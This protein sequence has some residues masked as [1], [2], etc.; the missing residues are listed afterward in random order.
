MKINPIDARLQTPQDNPLLT[1]TA[2]TDFYRTFRDVSQKSDLRD[3]SKTAPQGRTNEAE[4]SSRKSVDQAPNKTERNDSDTEHDSEQ[5]VTDNTPAR[6]VKDRKSSGDDARKSE[7]SGEGQPVASKK[8]T[9]NEGD[10][11]GQLEIE[12][13]VAAPVQAVVLIDPGTDVEQ[14]TPDTGAQEV[15]ASQASPALLDADI[16]QSNQTKATADQAGESSNNNITVDEPAHNT[17]GTENH[18]TAS[19]QSHLQPEHASSTRDQNQDTEHEVSA[20]PVDKDA[21]PLKSTQV[22]SAVFKEVEAPV[23]PP[24]PVAPESNITNVQHAQGPTLPQPAPT[25]QDDANVSRVLR[26][27]TGNVNQNGGTVSLRLRPPELGVV[28]IQMQVADGVVRAQ[29]TTEQDS[30]RD[31]LTHRI[32][33]LRHVLESKGLSV[34]RLDV[35]TATPATASPQHAQ[36]GHMDHQGEPQNPNDGRSRGQF[37]QQGHRDGAQQDQGR[38]NQRP[39]SFADELLNLV[40]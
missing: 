23:A 36:S 40:A 35:Q 33:Q 26:G 29:L 3:T 8:N 15:R 24:Q 25:D 6:V 5:A 31:L 34:E 38:A 12:D 10:S 37:G 16:A 19:R 22:Q 20:H 17:Q 18:H 39:Q 13:A 7:N 11:E 27:L 28:R 32:G 2:T 4:K 30:V 14:T 21:S 9:D 1:Q